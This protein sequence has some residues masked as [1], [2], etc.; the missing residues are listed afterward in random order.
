MGQHDSI[1]TVN[2]RLRRAFAHAVETAKTDPLAAIRLECTE[3]QQG[4]S[5]RVARCEEML[6]FLWPFREAFKGET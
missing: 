6:C 3:C 4:H 1:L 2:S 5:E